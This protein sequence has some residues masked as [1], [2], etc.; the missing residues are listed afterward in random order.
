MKLDDCSDNPLSSG[1]RCTN[2]FDPTLRTKILGGG[3]LYSVYSKDRWSSRSCVKGSGAT[4]KT[5]RIGALVVRDD[6]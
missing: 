5:L 3:G 4:R 2:K 1:E 6:E